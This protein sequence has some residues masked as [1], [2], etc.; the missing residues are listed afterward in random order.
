MTNKR[1]NRIVDSPIIGAGAYA[2]NNTFALSTTG[3]GEF[4]IRSV[5]AYDISALLE[6]NGLSLSQA[7]NE[8]VM[9]E[10][11]RKGGTGGVI[12]MDTEGNVSL[13]FNTEGMYQGFRKSS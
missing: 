4:F 7:A 3:H 1:W 2:N 9:I 6:Y 12:A 8:V 13:T 10:L 11:V 5:V